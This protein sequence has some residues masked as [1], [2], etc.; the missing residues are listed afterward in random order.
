MGSVRVDEFGDGEG[1]CAAAAHGTA[2]VSQ[3]PGRRRSD[4]IGEGMKAILYEEFGG[5]EVLRLAE[6][7]E[8]T[9][10]P[11]GSSRR[12]GCRRQQF[13]PRS[14]RR[15]VAALAPRWLLRH[16][17]SEAVGPDDL[18]EG[19]TGVSVGRRER[20]WG[21]P[22]FMEASYAEW[23]GFYEAAVAWWSC[24]FPRPAFEHHVV[25]HLTT[26]VHTALSGSALLGVLLPLESR[27]PGDPAGYM[28]GE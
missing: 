23:Y 27:G 24:S 6:V 22:G 5:S 7:E 21:E 3:D 13:G 1:V 20:Q 15:L 11:P 18:R 12:Y 25:R 16:P 17:G 14:R 26:A 19:A 4:H 10:A 8:P 28:L 2:G 9:S